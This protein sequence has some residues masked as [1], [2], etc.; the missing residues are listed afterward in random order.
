MIFEQCIFS[1]CP[2]LFTFKANP[3]LKTKKSDRQVARQK[4]KETERVR[5]KEN[6]YLKDK[7]K[8]LDKQVRR[9]IIR[10]TWMT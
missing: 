2:C 1:T 8:H 10:D 5:D 4:K 3:M 9:Y 6:R 7:H